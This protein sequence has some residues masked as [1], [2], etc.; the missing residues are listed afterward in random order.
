[1]Q[2]ITLTKTPLFKAALKQAIEVAES[3]QKEQGINS[4]K[5]FSIDNS[6][7]DFFFTGEQKNFETGALVGVIDDFAANFGLPL[8]RNCKVS[9]LNYNLATDA[10]CDAISEHFAK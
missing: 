4:L 1:M 5:G 10:L 7:C 9:A 8:D 6:L 3:E 2:S